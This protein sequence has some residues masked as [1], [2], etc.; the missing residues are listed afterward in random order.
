MLMLDT[1]THTVPYVRSCLLH[2][3]TYSDKIILNKQSFNT[4]AYHIKTN[5]LVNLYN[6]KGL[7]N[8]YNILWNST[9]NKYYE[10]EAG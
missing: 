2:K 3:F 6:Q 10:S 4:I 5:N 7:I 1:Q 8:M 9:I